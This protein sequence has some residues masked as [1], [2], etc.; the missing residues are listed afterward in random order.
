MTWVKVLPSELDA[1]YASAIVMVTGPVTLG[2]GEPLAL[3]SL[4]AAVDPPPAQADAARPSAA[5][6]AAPAARRDR[7]PETVARIRMMCEL[8]FCVVEGGD[9]LR[10][11]TNGRR[12]TR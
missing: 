4:E 5:I 11:G 2:S 1:V 6:R 9:V 7:V 10:A 12:V 3:L 8:S